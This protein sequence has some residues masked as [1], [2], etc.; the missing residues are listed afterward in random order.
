LLLPS[1]SLLLSLLPL[2]L[3]SLL[4][5]HASAHNSAGTHAHLPEQPG[6]ARH[7]RLFR[8]WRLPAVRDH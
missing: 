3:P 1:P 6:A 4:L 7:L 5:L 2:L 8:I